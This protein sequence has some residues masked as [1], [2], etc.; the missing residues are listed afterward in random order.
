MWDSCPADKVYVLDGGLATELERDGFSL[1][2]DPLW[3]AR[4]LHEKPEAI[5]R[6]HNRYLESGA[7]II[8]TASYQA[9]ISGFQKHLGLTFEQ[10]KNLLKLSV[11]L[12]HKARMQYYDNSKETREILVAGSI[13]SYGAALADGSEYTGN[14][15]DKLTQEELISWHRPQLT[16]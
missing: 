7:E 1:L 4:I 15:C 10:S 3:S 11:E 5:V 2:H 14:Y 12:A 6:V 8:I 9:S 13:G 16:V